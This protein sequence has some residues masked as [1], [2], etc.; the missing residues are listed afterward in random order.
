MAKLRYMVLAGPTAVGKTELAIRVARDLQTEIV[1]A[2]AFQI[3]QGLDILTG[4]PTLSQLTAIR[5]HLIGVLPLTELCDAHTYTLLASQTIAT[6][7]CQASAEGMIM[8]VL[9]P[10]AESLD[11]RY[12]K[13]LVASASSSPKL[14][15]VR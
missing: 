2:D 5:H 8:P 3:Y 10:A 6:Q 15:L 14:R 1:G 13:R 7:R 9:I 12:L 4:K 11:S